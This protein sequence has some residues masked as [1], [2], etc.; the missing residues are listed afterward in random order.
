MYLSGSRGFSHEQ[1][2]HR[3]QMSQRS[4]RYCD[5]SSSPWVEHPLLTMYRDEMGEEFGTTLVPS[6]QSR[7]SVAV[8]KLEAWLRMRGLDGLTARKQARGAA[9]GFLGNALFTEMIFTA[10]LPQWREM[11][12]QRCSPGADAE[13]R[14]LYAQVLRELKNGVSRHDDRVKTYFDDL[15]LVPSPDGIG[16]VVEVRKIEST[17][18]DSEIDWSSVDVGG[19]V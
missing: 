13:I 11:V 7:Y 8:S 14:V 5:E 12:M 1:V 6:A 17:L 4:T 15:S 9:R 3:F 18:F 16:E 19:V 10:N 2:R